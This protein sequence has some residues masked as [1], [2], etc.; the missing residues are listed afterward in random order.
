VP[1]VLDVRQTAPGHLVVVAEDGGRATPRI[2]DA[3]A[4][5]GGR[6]IAAEKYEPS[7]DD[8]FVALVER[9]GLNDAPEEVAS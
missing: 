1:G 7:F 6:V 2:T 5:A 9:S 3:V 4:A 8:V